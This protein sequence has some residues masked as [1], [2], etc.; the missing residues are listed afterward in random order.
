MMRHMILVAVLAAGA[1]PAHVMAANTWCSTNFPDAV[2]CD[3]FDRYCED[4]PPPPEACSSESYIDGGLFHATWVP[5][6]PCSSPIGLDSALAISLPWGAKTNTQE[7]ST[8]AVA[9]RG[10][11]DLVR[12]KYG[13]AYS[14]MAG[15]DLN[16]LVL[17]VA[18]RANR[19]RYDNSYLSLGS[20]FAVAPTDYAYSPFCGCTSPDPRYPVIC[21]QDSPAANCPP[22]S[23]WPHVACVAVGFVAYLDSDPCHCSSGGDHSPYNDHLSFY[24]GHQWYKLRQGLFPTGSGDF[25]LRTGEHRIRVTIRSTMLKVELTTPNTGE[26]SWCELPRDYLGTFSSF[27]AGYAVPCQLKTGNWECRGD[28]YD[29]VCG[30]G[31]PNGSVPYYDNI[32]LHGGIPYDAPGACCFP[33]TSCTPNLSSGDCQTLG[34]QPAGPGTTC[35][36]VACCPPL[37][38]DHD[39]DTDVDIED[40]AWFQTCLSSGPFVPPPTL[41]C[42]CAD[43][44]HDSDV[45]VADFDIFYNCM[46]GP[47]TPADPHCAD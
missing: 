24:D 14:T 28:P 45:D 43:L 31:A 20:N 32:A 40:F 10:F 27:M 42:E 34:G 4:P 35:A 38:P 44:D 29:P 16:P 30:D 23:T 37:K 12:A 9:K 6:G 11:A 21:A 47:G 46:L 15:T 33:D 13:Q 18:M 2:V 22:S 26:Y 3:D 25:Q 7:N 17:E 5:T 8:L 36:T 1:I 39:L 19:P 41:V